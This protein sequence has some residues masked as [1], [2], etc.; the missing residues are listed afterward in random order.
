MIHS[1]QPE[2]ELMKA[3][4]AQAA[5]Y[6][7]TLDVTNPA[8]VFA[9]TTQALQ[10]LLTYYTPTQSGVFSQ[11]QT[12]WHESGMIWGMFFD[13]AKWTGD[14]QFL[15]LVTDALVNISYVTEHAKVSRLTEVEY[16]SDFLG[17]NAVSVVQTLLGV[18]NDDLLWPSQAAVG[19][20]EVFGPNA[21][22]PRSNGDWISLA[23]KTYDQTGV[24]TDDKCGGGIYWSRDRGSPS[25]VYKSLITQIEFIS[26]GARNYLQTKN[27]TALA[28]SKQVLDWIMSSGL[29]NLNTG[30]LLDGMPSNNCQQFTKTSWSYNYGQLIGSLAWMN[31]ATKNQ[32][33]LD[34][35]SP[36]FDYS[37]KLFAPTGV[38]TEL[39]E[40]DVSC[41][42]DQQGFKAIY[43]RNLVYVYRQTTNATIKDAI[44]KMIDAS[45]NAMVSN[46]CDKQ[47][48]CGGNWTTDTQPVKYIRSQAVSAALLVS[49]I[50]IHGISS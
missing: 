44:Q 12:P 47:W 15:E 34:M 24:E 26:Q 7:P 3:S 20:A 43:A 41:N 18:W 37:V 40:A 1:R 28:Q 10:N 36:F 30:E 21:I 38:I 50:G 29:G 14:T 45:V 4:S 9:A 23:T 17:G 13:Y 39:C 19:G 6:S 25:G 42:R 32:T 46:S 2:T 22:M 8:Q 5:S 11:V 16:L 49:A 33:Y 27:E 31:L 48:N 35:I